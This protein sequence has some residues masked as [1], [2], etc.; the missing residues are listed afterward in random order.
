MGVTSVW[1]R[2]VK[3]FLTLFKYGFAR[4][5]T[6]GPA[7]VAHAKVTCSTGR[8]AIPANSHSKDSHSNFLCG[9][10]HF[11]SGECKSSPDTLNA[12]CTQA[13]K[14]KVQRGRAWF[15][16]FCYGAGSNL[17]HY[18]A[19]AMLACTKVRY[20]RVVHCKGRRSVKTPPTSDIAMRIA[21]DDP[22]CRIVATGRKGEIG[23]SL[24]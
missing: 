15:S 17:C 12:R 21:T 23:R 5:T 9:S 6:Q 4:S 22:A 7:S 3:T 20:P 11:G 8:G 13:Y 10:V 24:N 18:M 16:S 19:H 2:R 14:A 1:V